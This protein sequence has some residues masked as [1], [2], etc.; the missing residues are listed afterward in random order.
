MK[1]VRQHN[2]SQEEATRKVGLL[3]KRVVRQHGE[4]IADPVSVWTQ[5]TLDFSF[6]SCGMW[7]EGKVEVGE[8]DVTLDIGLPLFA[9][10]LE[11]GIRS[12]VERELSFLFPH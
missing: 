12:G 6:Q 4:E 2:L 1:V 7:F 5:D 10:P 9:E 11:E 3:L 8:S